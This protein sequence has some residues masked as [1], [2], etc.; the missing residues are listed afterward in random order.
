[1]RV[2]TFCA[3]C[4]TGLLLTQPAQA[5]FIKEFRTSRQPA[6]RSGGSVSGGGSWTESLTGMEFVRVPGGCFKMGSPANE[7]DRDSDE[8][9]VHE[10]CVDP[11]SMGKYEA[12]QGQ[13]HK[14]MGTNPAKFKHGDNY[15]VEQVGW[16]DVQEFIRTLNRQTGKT[17]RLPTEAE[18]EYVCRSGGKK[19]KYCGGD[20]VDALAW[21]D[22]NSGGKT[23]PV[24]QKQA[25]NLG[26][27]DMSGNVYEWCQDW[28]D[29][30]YYGKS[31]LQN[32][33]GPSSGSNRV[34]RGGSWFNRPGDVRSAFRGR[35]DPGY[36]YNY[37]GFRLVTQDR[38]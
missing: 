11:F 24:G 10:V 31:P 26:L 5:W 2:L 3:L 30:G 34:G 32:P 23:H 9:P 13:W 1:M 38:G 19:E 25:N 37:L 18:W 17:F 12:T 8:G 29:S 28:Y 27:Y 33:Q 36:R 16:N 15:P 35:S 4:I 7:S 20:N 6:S 14:V 22:K 21:Y